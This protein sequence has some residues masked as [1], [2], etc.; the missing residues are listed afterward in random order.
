MLPALQGTNALVVSLNFT[1]GHFSHLTATYRLLAESGRVPALYVHPL[2]NAMD[3][4]GVFRKLNAPAELAPLGLLRLAVFWFPSLKNLVEMARLRF[5]HGAKITYVFHEPFDSIANY[6]RAGFSRAR[7]AKIV[8]ING[9]SML[10]LCLAHEVILPSRVS[11]ELYLDKYRWLNRHCHRIAL[12]FDDEVPGGDIQLAAKDCIAYIGT[13]AA[14]HAFDR[15][16]DFVERAV[17]R[18]LLPG[19]TFA[20]ATRSEIPQRERAILARLAASGRVVV[21][22]GRALSTHE[23]NAFYRRSIVVWNAY[24]RS[25]QSG[26]LPKAFMFGAAVIASRG[27]SNEFVDDRVT[28][29]LIG[30]NSN[31]SEIASAAAEI[32]AHREKYASACRSKFLDT[33]YYRSK[34]NE[35]IGV[36]DR[37]SPASA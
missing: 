29:I 20:I 12:L 31:L 3:E 5:R 28:G 23:I 11:Y 1:P 9:V 19:M 17:T 27:L 26:V 14:D 16:V 18:G 6:R 25:N 2:F 15:F 8:L 33:F 30:D 36:I 4:Q 24:H 22:S 13:V 7:I 37:K 10:T 35:L 21:Q 34:M 32:C